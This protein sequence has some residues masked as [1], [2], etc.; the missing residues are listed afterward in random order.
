MDE[1]NRFQPLYAITLVGGFNCRLTSNERNLW[2][3]FVGGTPQWADLKRN[4]H[5]LNALFAQQHGTSADLGS[6]IRGIQ[7]SQEAIGARLYEIGKKWYADLIE[8]TVPAED[9]AHAETTE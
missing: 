5:R 1:H 7:E 8:A 4:V 2:H 6:D 3:E 9:H